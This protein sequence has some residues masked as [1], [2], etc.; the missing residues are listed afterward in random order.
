MNSNICLGPNSLKEWS[1]SS[2]L[3]WN[4]MIIAMGERITL[5]L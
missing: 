4:W 1:I 5:I 2:H 3:I